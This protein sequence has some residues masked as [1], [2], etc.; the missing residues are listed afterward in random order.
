MATE[1]ITLVVTE[2]AIREI[3][4]VATE[5]NER[6][7]NIGA[8]R[9]HTIVERVMGDISFEA[10]DMTVQGAPCSAKPRCGYSRHFCSRKLFSY[11]Q[12]NRR[13]SPLISRATV[14]R[15]PRSSCVRK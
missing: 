2:D 8:R 10:P 12:S 4:R 9:L 1:G 11:P 13:C 14:W 5:A 6:L 7:E 15:S 3:S